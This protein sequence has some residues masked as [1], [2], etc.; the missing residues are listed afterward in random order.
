M[1]SLVR[2]CGRCSSYS[3]VKP[4]L[5]SK[6]ARAFARLLTAIA[7]CSMRL[8]FM[9]V[10]LTP[11]RKKAVEKSCGGGACDQPRALPGLG[12][13]PSRASDRFEPDR[14]VVKAGPAVGGYG[15]VT[16]QRV[17][18]APFADGL[19]RPDALHDRGRRLLA[20]IEPRAQHHRAPV[21]ANPH[22]RSLAHPRPLR[23]ARMQAHAGP[24]FLGKRGRG[25][26]ER[27]VEEVAGGWTDELKGMARVGALVVARP[28]DHPRHHA[29]TGADPA[30]VRLEVEAGIRL[31][32]AFA[33]VGGFDR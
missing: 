16:D 29:V 33:E 23:R 10:L 7:T 12:S 11:A 26:R 4:S 22:L 1:A 3:K 30:P 25:L 8:T 31:R 24:S 18:G 15:I 5:S 6:M 2:Y 19:R 32:E 14:G 13:L 27:A 21:V 17:D 20:R 28:V 9:G